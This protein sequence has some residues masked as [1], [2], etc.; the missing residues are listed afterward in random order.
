MQ[1]TSGGCFWYLF[2]TQKANCILVRL[3]TNVLKVLRYIFNVSKR[4][5]PSWYYAFP[6]IKAMQPDDF[7]V[8]TSTQ[9]TIKKAYRNSWTLDLSVGRWTLDAGPWTLDAGPW[10]LDS[11]LWTLDAGLWTLDTG[12]WTLDA[13]C[14]ILDTGL[15]ALDTIVDCFKTKSEASFWFCL[16]KLLKILWVRISKDLM[17]TLVL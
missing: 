15:W 8:S 7:I 9:K 2:R 14:Y 1:N 11:K 5:E 3:R 17:V 10:T 12:L 6:K 13:G 4:E 16:I